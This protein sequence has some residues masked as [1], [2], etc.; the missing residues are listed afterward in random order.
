MCWLC[1]TGTEGLNDSPLV[2]TGKKENYGCTL[3]ERRE[4]RHLLILGEH[5]PREAIGG[6]G[7]YEL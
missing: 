5:C 3:L 4:V 7:V 2:H 6:C 1:M